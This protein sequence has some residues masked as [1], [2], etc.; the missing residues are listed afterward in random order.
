VEQLYAQ[1]VMVERYRALYREA[2]AAARARS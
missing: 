1:E 2:V